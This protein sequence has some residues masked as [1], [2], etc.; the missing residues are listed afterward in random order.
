MI[1]MI[2]PYLDVILSERSWSWSLIGILY[3][4][5]AFFVR[6]WFMN[7]LVWKAKQMDKSVYSAVK[8]AYLRRSVLGWFLFF[9]PL[10]LFTLYW[11]SILPPVVTDKM[12]AGGASACLITAILLHLRAFGLG[13]IA[14]LKKQTETSKEKN[15]YET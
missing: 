11:Q 7:S 10:G 15:L 2:K 3:V 8:A 9:L 13:A 4:L 6:S 1:T 12:V 14:V 5:A